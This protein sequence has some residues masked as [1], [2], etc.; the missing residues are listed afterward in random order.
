MEGLTAENVSPLVMC[1]PSVHDADSH[2][3]HHIK[4]VWLDIACVS[5]TGG[6]EAEGSEV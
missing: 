2:H 4:L 3:Q 6:V 1:F 5:S